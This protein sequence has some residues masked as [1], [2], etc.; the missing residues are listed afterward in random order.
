M[1]I[2]SQLKLSSFSGFICMNL[3]I[4]AEKLTALPRVI[5]LLKHLQAITSI[6]NFIFKLFALVK[7][8]LAWLKLYTV[9]YVAIHQPLWRSNICDVLL[10]KCDL[11]RI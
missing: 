11:L 2:L 10:T 6:S 4:T 3:M 8:A 1:I 7:I 9:P 5:H